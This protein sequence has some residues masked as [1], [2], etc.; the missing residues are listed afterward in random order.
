M[1]VPNLGL[2]HECLR[3]V[4]AGR[5]NAQFISDLLQTNGK[6]SS[7]L[8]RLTQDFARLC[9]AW[10]WKVITFYETEKSPTLEDTNQVH[11]ASCDQLCFTNLRSKQWVGE[12]IFRMTGPKVL[13]VDKESAERVTHEY[14]EL[15]HHPCPTGHRSLV[16]FDHAADD[17][18]QSLMRE[19][20]R[21]MGPLM[22]PDALQLSDSPDSSLDSD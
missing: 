4:V 5:P 6:P 14:R 12:T 7:F 9:R 13:M 2:N 19:I 17:R 21:T 1:G 15:D 22:N 16:R 3:T 18:Y 11:N 20:E 10:P 8:N